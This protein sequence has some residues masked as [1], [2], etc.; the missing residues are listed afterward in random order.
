MEYS[1]CRPARL[2]FHVISKGAC[3]RSTSGPAPT[4][5][6][7]KMRGLRGDTGHRCLGG[8]LISCLGSRY[9]GLMSSIR[10]LQMEPKARARHRSVRRM[11]DDHQI[12]LRNQSL[13]TD[14]GFHGSH[15]SKRLTRSMHAL[16]AGGIDSQRGRRRRLRLG[17]EEPRLH[18]LFAEG[19]SDIF[20]TF[21]TEPMTDA[22]TQ[23]DG[24][25]S[26]LTASVNGRHLKKLE[27]RAERMTVSDH[28]PSTRH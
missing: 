2:P 11:N 5:A 7:F 16:V 27:L 8:Q 23:R 22:D 26:L 24:V 18:Y 1:R 13:L 15:L 14:K 3:R 10:R 9:R 21:H 4:D 20:R 17:H 12:R 28:L 25:A 6:Y 19:D